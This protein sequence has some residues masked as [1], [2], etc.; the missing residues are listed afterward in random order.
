MEPA[1][2]DFHENIQLIRRYAYAKNWLS[3]DKEDDKED[4]VDD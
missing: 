1:K 2:K 4:A 3:K